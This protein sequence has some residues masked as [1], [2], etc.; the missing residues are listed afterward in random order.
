MPNPLSWFFHWLPSGFTEL[1]VLF[2]HFTELIVPFGYLI[3]LRWVLYVAGFFHGRCFKG[4]SSCR[5]RLSWL[6]YHDD[7]GRH[8]AV[9]DDRFP[10]PSPHPESRLG[11]FSRSLMP[12]LVAAGSFS[13]WGSRDSQHLP[14]S[15]P[16]FPGRR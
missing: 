16:V 5:A 7:R 4:R 2:N 12:H 13:P 14:G 3:P 10:I 9:F 8:P 1:G 15:Q 6:N 11:P